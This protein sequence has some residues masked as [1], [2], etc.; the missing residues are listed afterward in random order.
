MSSSDIKAKEGDVVNLLCSAQG[1]PP[2]TFHWEKDKN[3]LKSFTENKILL[4][5]SLLVLTMKNE[6]S[7]G[8]YVCHARNRFKNTFHTIW[9]Q[10]LEDTGCEKYIAGII[11]L[12]IFLIILIVILAYFL[13]VIRRFKTLNTNKNLEGKVNRNIKTDKDQYPENKDDGTYEE[14]EL[15]EEQSNY[16]SLKRPG[17]RE[18]DDK[19]YTH[20][21]KSNKSC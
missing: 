7:F 19:L 8:K 9:I 2:I 16:T 10:K 15:K 11:V 3:K 13:H 14:I 12:T 20:L 21:V 5:S 4:R 1:E 18:T 6:A 17:E